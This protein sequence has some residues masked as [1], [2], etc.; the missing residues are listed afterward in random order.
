VEQAI[1]GFDQDEVGDWRAILACG[2]R[3]HVRHNPPLV[4]RPWVLTAA[5]RARFVGYAL[6]CKRCDEANAMYQNIL[7]PLDGSAVAE[8]S[9]PYALQLR[10]LSGGALTLVRVVPSAVHPPAAYSL[11]EPEPWLMRQEA[12][13][14]EA[15]GYLAEVA[16]R[17]ELAAAGPETL[18][19]AGDVS[20]ALLNLTRQGAYDVLVMTTRD[21]RDPVRW[22]LGSVADYL[23]QR[24]A[25]PVLLVREN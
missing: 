17:P 7:V 25:L 24:A 23:V 4:E 22:V 3:Q 20:Q 6:D 19:I 21:R 5:G 18:V 10:R 16:A 9:L 13:R 15:E 8:A 11:A 1:V 12:L 2:H 14:A